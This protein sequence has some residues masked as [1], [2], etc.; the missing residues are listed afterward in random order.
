MRE[1]I[2]VCKD[3]SAL[4]FKNKYYLGLFGD[5]VF[6]WLNLLTGKSILKTQTTISG[7]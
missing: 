1:N 7:S 4:G 2:C 6:E 3:L 5:P